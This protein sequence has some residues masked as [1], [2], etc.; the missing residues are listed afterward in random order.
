MLVPRSE[1]NNDDDGPPLPV[2]V[3]IPIPAPIPDPNDPMLVLLCTLDDDNEDLFMSLLLG[4]VNLDAKSDKLLPDPEVVPF[5]LLALVLNP[6][7]PPLLVLL[8]VLLLL[9]GESLTMDR[10]PSLRVG[11]V[12]ALL[13]LT[14]WNRPVPPPASEV[15][16][17]FFLKCT[18]INA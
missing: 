15:S 17:F 16:L 8:L 6:P 18:K 14:L 4:D 1:G 10:N 2:L 12:V 13:L 9:P 7:P 11:F 3:P 5:S